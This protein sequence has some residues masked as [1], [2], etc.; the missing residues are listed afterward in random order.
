PLVIVSL[1]TFLTM[2]ESVAS[3][4]YSF[5]EHNLIKMYLRSNSVQDRLGN[6]ALLSIDRQLTNVV[7]FDS[8]TDEFATLK[9]RK[10]K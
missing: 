5:S 2:C 6:L 7:D 9:A 8:V 10:I 1:T 4:E 3:C